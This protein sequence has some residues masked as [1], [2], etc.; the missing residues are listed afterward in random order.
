MSTYCY[1]E[2]FGGLKSPKD[3]IDILLKYF[4]RFDPAPILRYIN[5]EYLQFRLPTWVEGSLVVPT[6]GAL[7]RA[8]FAGIEESRRY[9]YCIYLILHKLEASRYF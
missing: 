8:Y 4:R 7:T 3:Q 2:E 1:P 9:S 5:E 6:V